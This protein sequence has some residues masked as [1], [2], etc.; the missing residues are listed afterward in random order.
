M[1]ESRCRVAYT[2]TVNIE[3]SVEVDADSVFE[4]AA[5]AVKHFRDSTPQLDLPGTH[6]ELRVTV[7]PVAGIEHK[8]KLRRVEEWALYGKAQNGSDLMRKKR[9]CEMLKLKRA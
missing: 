1:A 8:I 2:D 7:F 9:V 3:H 4:A 5:K 6:S